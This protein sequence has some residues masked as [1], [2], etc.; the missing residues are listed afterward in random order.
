MT[1]IPY[2]TEI[3]SLHEFGK[4]LNVTPGMLTWMLWPLHILAGLSLRC[5]LVISI[6]LFFFSF[7]HPPIPMLQIKEACVWGYVHCSHQTRRLGKTTIYKALDAR[8]TQKP[9]PLLSQGWRF[10]KPASKSLRQLDVQ[11]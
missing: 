11:N 10:R 3:V 2:F 9:S 7:F 4:S 8:C 6:S 5:C 1:I